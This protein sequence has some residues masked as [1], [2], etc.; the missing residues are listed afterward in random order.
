VEEIERKRSAA[1]TATF[2]GSGA[3]LLSIEAE[4]PDSESQTYEEQRVW[5][6]ELIDTLEQELRELSA[7]RATPAANTLEPAGYSVSHFQIRDMSW[8][9]DPFLI[10]EVEREDVEVTADSPQRPVWA[11]QYRVEY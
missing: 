5:F 1:G 6:R 3:L 7:T 10:P 4:T 9:V 11:V 2:R 8:A